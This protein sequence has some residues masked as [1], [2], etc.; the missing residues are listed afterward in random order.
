MLN[1]SGDVLCFC[2]S[3][4]DVIYLGEVER[5]L[6]EKHSRELR[7]FL[8]TSVTYS[9]VWGYGLWIIGLFC[10]G[11]GFCFSLLFSCCFVGLE[12]RWQSLRVRQ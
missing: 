4:F 2:G 5:N 8:V 12:D 9:L 3:Y 1:F 6:Y 7:F 11:V 10:V